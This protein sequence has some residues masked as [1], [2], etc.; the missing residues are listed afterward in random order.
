M[1]ELFKDPKSWGNGAWIFLHCISYTYPE[2]PSKKEEKYYCSFFNNLGYVIPCPNCRK[3]YQEYLK[4]FPC[5]K[6]LK[7]K[8][9]LSKWLFEL[10]NYVNFKL[11]KP[12]I[13][14][15]NISQQM[16]MK[17]I[18]QINQQ[19]NKYLLKN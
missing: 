16:V 1:D 2:I 7:N 12:L 13:D 3:H 8:S 19:Q 4:Q 9:S 6:F 17:Q 10:H 15:F 18:Y 11:N 5:S 14:D